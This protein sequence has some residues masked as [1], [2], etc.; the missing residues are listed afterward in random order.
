MPVKTKPAV[1]KASMN[2]KKM[3]LYLMKRL[4][5]IK[6]NFTQEWK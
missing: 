2:G 5:I 1:K 6:D 4:K 3:L